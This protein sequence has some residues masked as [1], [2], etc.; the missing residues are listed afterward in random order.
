MNTQAITM[1]HLQMATDSYGTVLA[2]GDYVLA[3][4]YRHLG[5][6]KIGND[7]RVYKLAEQPIPGF[8]PESR[9]RSEC[10]LDLV[11]EADQLFDDAGHAIAWALA[12][13]PATTQE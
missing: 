4:A 10:V 13:I 6:G 11:A 5:K 3:S 2:Y 12:Q 9:S 8:G 1:E 7:A